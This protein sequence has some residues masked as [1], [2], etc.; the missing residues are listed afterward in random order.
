MITFKCPAC[1]KEMSAAE[2][3]AGKMGLC[4]G[5]QQ[6]FTIPAASLGIQPAPAVERDTIPLA[7]S[8]PVPKTKSLPI[9]EDDENFAE[10]PKRA[11]KRIA[12]DSDDDEP[13]KRKRARKGSSES[14]EADDRSRKRKRHDDE[15]EENVFDFDDDEDSGPII[16]R[17]RASYGL[18]SGTRV[19]MYLMIGLGVGLVLAC[20]RLMIRH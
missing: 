20:F 7:E 12:N 8:I 5:C 19:A 1:G 18:N 9:E 6:T 4:P 13:P 10:V 15:E 2:E 17:R 11:K 14:D 3:H 16:P